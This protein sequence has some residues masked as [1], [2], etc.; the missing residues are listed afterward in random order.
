MSHKKAKLLHTEQNYGGVDWCRKLKYKILM[1]PLTFAKMLVR[2]N[3]DDIAFIQCVEHVKD[4]YIGTWGCELSC[5]PTDK[6]LK[7]KYRRK[8]RKEYI[9]NFTSCNVAVIRC[10]RREAD[11]VEVSL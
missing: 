5:I 7:L 9:I 4:E 10:W 1:N 8:E 6:F 11:I 2:K 3:L